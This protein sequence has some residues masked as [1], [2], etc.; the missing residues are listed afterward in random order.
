LE[1]R[2]SLKN[3]WRKNRWTAAHDLDA[4]VGKARSLGGKVGG[5]LAKRE[6]FQKIEAG[7]QQ[8]RGGADSRQPKGDLEKDGDRTIRIETGVL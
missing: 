5:G 3:I 4:A 8:G 1:I 2:E 6:E 7:T